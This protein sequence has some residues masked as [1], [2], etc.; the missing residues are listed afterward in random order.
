MVKHQA[1]LR[2]VDLGKSEILAVTGPG[3]HVALPREQHGS[4][5][6]VGNARAGSIKLCVIVNLIVHFHTGQRASGGADYRDA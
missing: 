2:R 4:A 3:E 6:S 5:G 1:C